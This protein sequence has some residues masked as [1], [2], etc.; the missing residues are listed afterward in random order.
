MC[1]CTHVKLPRLRRLN[2]QV[3][4]R[5]LHKRG[6][7]PRYPLN[8]R[9]G[10]FQSRSV[11]FGEMS[12]VH[13]RNRTTNHRFAVSTQARSFFSF[14]TSFYIKRHVFRGCRTKP[15]GEGKERLMPVCNK[16]SPHRNKINISS[17]VCSIQI[18][19]FSTQKRF[20][21]NP[22]YSYDGALFHNQFDICVTCL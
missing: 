8:R 11:S 4:D 6:N 17:M 21:R 13:V 5:R 7:G 15:V 3:N 18:L 20:V 10:L 1:S 16:E 9:T 12:L 14:L 22:S 19:F 2:V